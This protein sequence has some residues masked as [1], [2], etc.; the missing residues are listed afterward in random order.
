MPKPIRKVVSLSP[1]LLRYAECDAHALGLGFSQYF[2]MLLN[3]RRSD[4][5]ASGI[6]VVERGSFAYSQLSFDKV[7]HHA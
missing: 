1:D 7:V 3:G 2:S 5:L 6:D 4:Q